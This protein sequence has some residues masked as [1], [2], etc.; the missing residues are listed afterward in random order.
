MP[1]RQWL[2]DRSFD[3]GRDRLSPTPPSEPYGRFSRIRLSS[4]CRRLG[5]IETALEA[6]ERRPILYDAAEVTRAGPFVSI[7]TSGALRV[8][9]GYVRPEDEAPVDTPDDEDAEHTGVTRFDAA[10]IDDRLD[11]G[12]IPSVVWRRITFARAGA[13]SCN[14]YSP[15][16]SLWFRRRSYC[17]HFFRP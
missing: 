12:A 10:Q 8:E 2:D 17:R 6:F 1:M 4:R 7:D 9:R 3:R 14:K 13:I 11:A 15:H 5:E 16:A